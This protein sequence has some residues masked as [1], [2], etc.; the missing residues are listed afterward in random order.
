[1]L[2]DIRNEAQAAKT[3]ECLTGVIE[4]HWIEEKLKNRTR[5]NYT[6]VEKDIERIIIKNR[7]NFPKLEDIELVVTHITT[8]GNGCKAILDKGLV[9]L[10]KAYKYSE[11][12]LRHFLDKHGVE[13]DID[14]NWLIYKDQCYDISYGRCPIDHESKEYA[15]WSVGRKFHFDFTVCGF[16]SL[17]ENDVYGGWVHKRPEIL[18]D[19]DELLETTLQKQWQDRHRAYEIVFKVPLLNTAYNGWDS[20]TEYEMIMEYLVDAYM[21]IS[22]GP[23]TKEILCQNGLEIG[24][25]QILECNK[26]ELWK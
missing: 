14:S 8:S 10:V 18:A 5:I 17:N 19:I 11:S 7:G 21:C 12:E 9:D 25:D 23:N 15:A 20:D 13:I 26:F 22:T 2:Y 16:L 6:N 24:A 1:M 4:T 3:L